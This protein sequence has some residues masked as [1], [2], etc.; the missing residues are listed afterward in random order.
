MDSS[1]GYIAQNGSRRENLRKELTRGNVGLET[2]D[3]PLKISGL[4]S[5]LYVRSS[6]VV[7]S[8]NIV[9]LVFNGAKLRWVSDKLQYDGKYYWREIV[10]EN[11]TRGYSA[12]NAAGEF[13]I[14]L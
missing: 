1:Y 8:G 6:P 9:G 13:K 7:K 3:A 14:T 11:G 5:S 4:T 12:T 10:L 2:R